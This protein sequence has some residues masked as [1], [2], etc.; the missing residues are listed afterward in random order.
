MGDGQ[1]RDL[2]QGHRFPRVPMGCH[3]FF[4]IEL[5]TLGES[6]GESLGR[7]VVAEARLVL[8]VVL[9]IGHGWGC[10]GGSVEWR[11]GI[12]LERGE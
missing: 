4:R 1:G 2:G 9:D 7:E 12:E 10:G 3:C 11:R 6:V 8:V 5:H